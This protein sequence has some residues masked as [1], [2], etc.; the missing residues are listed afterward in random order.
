MG[1]EMNEVWRLKQKEIIIEVQNLMEVPVWGEPLK[2]ATENVEWGASNWSFI[3]KTKEVSSF[4]F[5][6]SRS[7]ITF[8]SDLCH[9]FPICVCL[10]RCTCNSNRIVN[11]LRKLNLALKFI[12][13]CQKYP[14]VIFENNEF[15]RSQIQIFALVSK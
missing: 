1:L 14:Q 2:K 13:I 9:T 11:D 10:F 12:I 5:S 4:N 6:C 8:A 3:G 15:W 7:A